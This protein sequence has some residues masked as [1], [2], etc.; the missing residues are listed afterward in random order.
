MGNM[1]Y[2]RFQNTSRDFADCSDVIDDLA[3]RADDPSANNEPSL[4]REEL[5][6]A[7]HL[8]NQARDFL[9]RIAEFAGSVGIELPE[10]MD[11]LWDYDFGRIV[12]RINVSAAAA[13]E[14]DDES[15]DE[16]A[17]DA[18]ERYLNS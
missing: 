14:S 8:A 9:A 13:I 6:S 11:V 5:E 7:V 16:A 18:H 2:C 12:R 10:S 1:S 3:D 17:A 4:S 15:D